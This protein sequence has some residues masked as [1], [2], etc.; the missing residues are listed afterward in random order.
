MRILNLFILFSVV[1]CY[2]YIPLNINESVFITYKNGK[3]IDTKLEDVK[4]EY[5]KKYLHP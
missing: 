2:D 3:R 5:Q 1:T 4:K